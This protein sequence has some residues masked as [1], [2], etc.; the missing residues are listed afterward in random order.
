MDIN[1]VINENAVLAV[2][3]ICLTAISVTYLL[4][5]PLRNRKRTNRDYAD[6]E[7]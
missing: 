2:M 7:K 5:M 6:W 4:T 3:L 1:I